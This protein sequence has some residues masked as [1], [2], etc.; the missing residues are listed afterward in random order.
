MV[1]QWWGELVGLVGGLGSQQPIHSA[2][3]RQQSSAVFERWKIEEWLASI[4]NDDGQPS[5]QPEWAL[6]KMSSE[7]GLQRGLD[8]QGCNHS[9]GARLSSSTL[10]VSERAMLKGDGWEGAPIANDNPRAGTPSRSLLS[11]RRPSSLPSLLNGL[12]TASTG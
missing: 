8:C 11:M 5:P 10:R 1:G 7:A 6:S 3:L 2:K 4:E 9:G 12:G